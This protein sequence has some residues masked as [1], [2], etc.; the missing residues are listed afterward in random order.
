MKSFIH[1]IV[2]ENRTAP[3]YSMLRVASNEGL[4]H[5]SPGQYFAIAAKK[6]SVQTPMRCFSA[7]SIPGSNELELVFRRVGNSTKTLSKLNKGDD[8][9]LLGP[10]GEFTLNYGAEPVVL[11]S[12]GIGITPFISMLRDELARPSGRQITVLVSAQSLSDLPYIQSLRSAVVSRKNIR[13]KLFSGQ[14]EQGATQGRIDTK[15]IDEVVSRQSNSSQYYICGPD[16]FAIETERSLESAGVNKRAIHSESF[17]QAERSIAGK[18]M[19]QTVIWST[20][21]VSG[22]LFLLFVFAN[23]IGDS[24]AATSTSTSSTESSEASEAVDDTESDDSST[25]GTSSST[26][27]PSQSYSQPSSSTYSQPSSTA[28]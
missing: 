25:T 1:A 15:V 27:T 14:P 20:L 22:I 28:S 3:T 19:V 23:A 11:I 7:V 10:F 16:E 21:S 8:V 4:P 18:S 24:Q 12:S 13:L 17:A 5:F 2:I 6:G 9:T 26:T